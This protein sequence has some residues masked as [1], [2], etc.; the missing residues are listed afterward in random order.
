MLPHRRQE[1]DD[2]VLNQSRNQRTPSSGSLV[3]VGS[4]RT[5]S[6]GSAPPPSEVNSST[7]ITYRYLSFDTD[8]PPS[9][10][11]DLNTDARESLALEP[12]LSPFVSPLR[13]PWHRKSI[14]LALSC[15]ATFL[16]AYT[17]GSY[18]PAIPAMAQD[19]GASRIGTTVGITTFCLGFALC[20][21]LLA[22]I[23]EIYGRRLVLITSGLVYV[24]FQGVC[25]VMPNLTGMLISRFLVGAGGSTFSSVIGGVIA[26][27]WTKEGRNAPMA[28]FSGFVLAGTGAGPLIASVMMKRIGQWNTTRAWQWVFWHQ[29]IVDAALLIALVFWLDETRGPVLLSRKAKVINRWYQELEDAGAYG[30]W[31]E[32]DE[33]DTTASDSEPE[34][35]PVCEAP[36]ITNPPGIS[37]RVRLRWLVREDEER[38]SLVELT[39][40]SL[41]RPFHLLFAEPVVFFF[42][43]WCA[44]AWAVLYL[45]FGSIALAF[46]RMRGLDVEESGYFFSAMIVGSVIATI[47]GICQDRLLHLPQWR[48]D[49]EPPKGKFMGAFWRFLRRRCPAESPE[50]RL[51]FT[52]ITAMLLPA[53]LFL[54]GF[55]IR[56]SVHWFAPASGIALSTWGIYSVYLATFNYFADIYHKYASSALA[57]Q[58]FCRNILGGVFPLVTRALIENLG[59]ERA[60]VLLGSIAAGLTLIPWALVFSGEK[61]RSKSRF[62][63]SLESQ[64]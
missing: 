12:D 24:A 62:A 27:M 6:R 19:L 61:I 36:S 20:P 63:L 55:T 15:I 51:Y 23:S 22:P 42:S 2:G 37:R 33:A 60:G 7:P 52:C 34:K 49:C 47:V 48:A 45:Q 16:T 59:E 18:S 5:T 10:V 17:A 21:M 35:L 8:L 54:F 4:Q 56:P 43:L 64:R 1:D 32:D 57:A 26:D 31:V 39:K 13:W 44:F 58:S 25:S 14:V 41:V 3:L 46:A 53:G 50:S 28:L 40:T 30:V 11:N 38:A 29:V 9:C